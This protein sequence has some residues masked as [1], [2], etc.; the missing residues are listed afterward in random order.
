MMKASK[1]TT[2]KMLKQ[3]RA[4][5]GNKGAGNYRSHRLREVFEIWKACQDQDC[6]EARPYPRYRHD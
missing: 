4:D 2:S 1:S 3:G 6:L 5:R